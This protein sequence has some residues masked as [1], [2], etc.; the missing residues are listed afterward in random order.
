MTGTFVP[1]VLV[2]SLLVASSAWAGE[3][4]L[5]RNAM[6]FHECPA[7]ISA[8]LEKIGADEN[9]VQ[10]VSDTGAHY[11]VELESTDANLQF[12][13]NA[14]TEQLEVARVTPGTLNKLASD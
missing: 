4:I 14:V 7:V 9:H 11:Y 13:C 1:G 10:T 3:E 5:I 8:M 2:C 6:M 12:R